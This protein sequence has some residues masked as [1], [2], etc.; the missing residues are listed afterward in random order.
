MRAFFCCLALLWLLPQCGG[1][2]ATGGD[3]KSAADDGE[4]PKR[5]YRGAS[6]DADAD[7]E[8]SGSSAPA[9]ERSKGPNC[10]DGTCSPCGGGICPAGW[11]CDEKASGGG[12]CSWL[13]ECA[14][15]PTCG[16]V[17]RVL[18]AGCKCREENGGLKVACD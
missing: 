5:P 8:E 9:T 10:D 11:Y 2:G 17:T 3:T 14:E 15:K 16:C 6:T 18:G 12:A 13:A 7:E 1:A 4:H